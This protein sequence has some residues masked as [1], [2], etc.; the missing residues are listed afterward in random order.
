MRKRFRDTEAWKWLRTLIE[1]LLIA[2][3]IYGLVTLYVSFGFSEARADEYDDITEG[4]VLCVDYVNVRPFPNRKGEPLGRFESGDKVYLDGRKRNGFLHII[5]TGL[6]SD[7]WIYA[8]Y[9]VYDEPIAVYQN[10]TIV[11]KARLAARKCVNG[12]RSRWLKPLATV[13]V[14]WWSDEWSVTSCGYLKTKFL[15]LEGE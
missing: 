6:E 4:W 11:S 9:I 15:E 12:K 13:K 8:G 10:A 2:L 14:Y 3:A 1:I 7:G 5:D